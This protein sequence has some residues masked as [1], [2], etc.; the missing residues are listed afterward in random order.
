MVSWNNLDTLKSFGE[1]GSLK[2]VS[3]KDVMSGDSGEKRAKEY[4]VPMAC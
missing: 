1:L 2:K 4:S 3:V